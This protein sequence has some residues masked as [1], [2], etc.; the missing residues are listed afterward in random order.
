MKWLFWR[1]PKERNSWALTFDDGPHPVITPKLLDVLES[2]GAKA[3]FF[4]TGKSA[5]RWPRLVDQIAERG[6]FIASH[7]YSHNR[8]WWRGRET[9][10]VELDDTE[11]ALGKH[12]ST[13]KFFRPPFGLLGPGWW[14]AARDREYR[15]MM[16]NLA[17]QDWIDDDAQRVADRVSARLAPGKI[18][19]FHECRAQTSEGYHHTIRAVDQV[20]SDAR[21]RGLRVETPADWGV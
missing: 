16:W 3:T 4:L 20:L 6:H 10:R 18:V 12:L 11:T 8:E 2:H 13:P 7:G 17:S 21:A 1:V 14:Y 15:L 19:L 9:M 5:G